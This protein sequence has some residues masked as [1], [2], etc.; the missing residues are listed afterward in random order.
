MYLGTIHRFIYLLD[1]VHRKKRKINLGQ[2]EL[3]MPTWMPS[4]STSEDH[5]F[6]VI[7]DDSI[8]QMSLHSSHQYLALEHSTLGKKVVNR[9]PMANAVNV[10]LDDRP[11]VQGFC[12]IVSR[13]THQFHSSGMGTMVRLGTDEGREEAVVN[14]DDGV[15][16]GVA[17]FVSDDLHVP[18]QDDEVDAD[19][20]HQFNLPV[21]LIALRILGNLE[22][23]VA[24]IELLGH[25]AQIF[26]VGDDEG[27]LARKL[28][29]LVP[30]QKFP[31]CVVVFRYHYADFLLGCAP[32]DGV[33]HAE[34][35]AHFLYPVAQG[36]LVGVERSV[37]EHNA[38][39]E[40]LRFDIRMLFGV[41]YVAAVAVEQLTERGDD[42][43]A[44][45]AD[46]PHGSDLGGCHR[47]WRR[48]A[49]ISHALALRHARVGF[50]WLAANDTL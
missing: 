16:E 18:G 31:Y 4:L 15:L 39:E 40:V 32:V 28:A 35:R 12:R 2:E 14:V 46:D 43:F 45:G 9:M 23:L 6:V 33:C 5:T 19:G 24:D 38:L 7:D 17:E 34:P 21:L 25:W 37:I 42:S 29:R 3:I 22:D 48:C 8:L 20:L 11:F 36:R 49:L 1:L 13:R 27:D 47:R 26:V 44:V 10:L 30:E 50:L 41:Q